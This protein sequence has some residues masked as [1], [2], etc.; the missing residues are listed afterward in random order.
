[1][2]VYYLGAGASAKTLPLNSNFFSHPAFDL[3]TAMD[4]ELKKISDSNKET[5]KEHLEIVRFLNAISDTLTPDVYARRLFREQRIDDFEDLKRLIMA[6]LWVLESIQ[7]VDSRYEALLQELLN[8]KND[9]K[10]LSSDFAMISWNYDVQIE[11][12]LADMLFTKN[13]DTVARDYFSNALIEPIIPYDKLTLIKLNGSITGSDSF[14]GKSSYYP[15]KQ[16]LLNPL[17]ELIRRY[18]EIYRDY[19]FGE[20]MLMK[21]SWE[22]SQFSSKDEN[23]ID[24]KVL[25]ARDLIKAAESIVVLG[26]SFQ[27]DNDD[28][29]SFILSNIRA[30]ATIYFQCLDGNAEAEFNF[31]DRLPKSFRVSDRNLIKIPH[32]NRFHIPKPK[33]KPNDPHFTF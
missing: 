23:Q 15:R 6:Y 4:V 14:S 30:D 5:P 3:R 29:D 16:L 8:Q 18:N 33:A 26:Y 13:V 7:P 27:S 28:T 12:C 11:K 20:A 32:A 19:R 9:S 31:R 2:I 25:Y 21:F 10:L 22:E 17:E 24:P 1:M